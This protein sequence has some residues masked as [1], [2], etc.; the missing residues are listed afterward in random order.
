MSPPSSGSACHLLGSF[1]DPEDGDD[2]LALNGLHS[3]ISK[4]IE[5]FGVKLKFHSVL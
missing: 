5:L 3:V 4:K 1:F 2:M